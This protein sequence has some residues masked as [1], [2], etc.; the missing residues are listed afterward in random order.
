MDGFTASTNVVVLAG[1]NRIDILDAAL[2]RA[3]RFDRQIM[4]DRPDIQGRKEVFLVH[5]R[6]LNLGEGDGMAQEQREELAGRLAALTPGF[7]G[8]DVANICNEAAIQAARSDKSRVELEDF[9]KAIDRVI[10]G[11]ESHRL[12]SK[13]EKEIVAYHEAGHAVA[14]WNLEHADPLLKVTILPR[15]SGALGFAQYLP[16]EVYLRTQEQMLDIICMALA[17]RAAEQ[18]QFGR[19]TT[20]ASDDLRRVTDMV[21]QMIKVYGMNERI[22]QLAFPKQDNGG[23]PDERPYS[24]ATAEAMDE[25]ARRMV[26][27][28]YERTLGLVRDKMDQVES[29]A[30]ALLEK[31]TISHDDVVELI[32]HRPFRNNQTYEDYVNSAWKK[33]DGAGADDKGEKDADDK[34]AVPGNLNPSF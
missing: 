1:T 29:V 6:G 25:E 2:T 15:T 27:E 17:G 16:K 12:L 20:G 4:V 13:E 18:V 8:A 23:F 32:G 34:G 10:G 31:E 5:M 21:Y 30:Q 28:A 22:G 14:G 33:K 26:D 3:G 7:V 19:V 24:E 11:L 9:E